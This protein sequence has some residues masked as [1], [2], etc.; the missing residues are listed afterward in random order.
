MAG[1][2]R[3]ELQL[4]SVAELKEI[5]K[6]EGYDPAAVRGFEKAELVEKTFYLCANPVAEDEFPMPLYSN[7]LPQFILRALLLA[8]LLLWIGSY[9]A[10]WSVNAGFL[11]VLA[12]VLTYR[13]IKIGREKAEKK[14][15]RR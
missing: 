5:L 13:N 10:S 8:G 9:L 2:T 12:A 14:R 15:K 1:L 6:R 4:K 3:E 7:C 11:V